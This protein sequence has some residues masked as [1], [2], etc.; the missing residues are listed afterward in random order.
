VRGRSWRFGYRRLVATLGALAL[1]ASTASVVAASM[2]GWWTMPRGDFA[3]LLGFVDEELGAHADEAVGA[4]AA[5][6]PSRVLWIGEAG[7]LPGG[8][9]WDLADHR[10]YTASTTAVPQVGDL[11]PATAS[12]GSTGLR[13]ALDQALGHQTT[14]LGRLLAPLGVGYVALPRRL[15]PSDDTRRADLTADLRAALAE[16]LDLERVPVDPGLVLY[17]NTAFTAGPAGSP[18]GASTGDPGEPA[19]PP[20]RSPAG[21]RQVLAAQLALWLLALALGLRMLFGA[22]EP[23]QPARQGPLRRRGRPAAGR[24][25]VGADGHEPAGDEAA[26]VRGGDGRRAGVH[27]NDVRG[28]AQRAG[29]AASKVDRDSIGARQ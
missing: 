24:V 4:S 3:G 29:R 23:R 19:E 27:A 15:A 10:S 26:D 20:D 1:V 8:D 25:P 6:S 11:W 21:H 9:G 18:A 28:E 12:P 14:R 16:Q 22:D 2:D 7:L 17:R 13:Q 5:G